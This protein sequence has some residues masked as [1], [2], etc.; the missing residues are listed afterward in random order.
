MLGRRIARRSP[1]KA[2]ASNR[3][4]VAAYS[5][6]QSAPQRGA[7]AR[8]GAG[9]MFLRTFCSAAE[10]K[11]DVTICLAVIVFGR[12]LRGRS[13]GSRHA[14]F[15]KS[16]TRA[17]SENRSRVFH[18]RRFGSAP[19]TGP[20][21]CASRKRLRLDASLCCAETSENSAIPHVI[22]MSVAHND[23]CLAGILSSIS[24]ASVRKHH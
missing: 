18:E 8:G 5:A 23:M 11:K 14:W 19:L 13:P 2:L 7:E 10:R 21:G 3:A 6:P 4:A 20:S 9:H 15:A 17:I 22:F 24:S 1:E 12:E 16:T